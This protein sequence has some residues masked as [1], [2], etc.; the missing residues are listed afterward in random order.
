MATV[1]Y[2]G[3]GDGQ[4]SVGRVISRAFGFIA[5]S[6]AIALGSALLFG[7]LPSILSQVLMTTSFRGVAASN[8]SSPLFSGLM[9]LGFLSFV[10]AMVFSGLMQATITRGLVI[11]HEGGRPSFGQ[12]LAGGMRYALPIV[13]LIILWSIAVGFGFMLLMIP[14]LILI[15]MWS[16]AVPALVEENTGVFGAFSR[17]RE[18]TRGARWK[19]FGLL[20]M[21]LI[22]YYL[23]SMVLGLVGLASVSRTSLMLDPA[24][25]LPIGLL[26]GSAISGAI[27][28]LLWATIQP[29]LFVE[30]RDAREGGGA[31]DLQQVFA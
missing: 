27:F 17:S 30:L 20:I 19:I 6:P 25:G 11:E 3:S 9:F 22:I 7:A 18:L 21:L 5:S 28:T 26:V 15:T 23:I 31:G 16:V 4:V 1:T 24:A 14:G 13:G 10:V 2:Q 8:A 29:S 12:C